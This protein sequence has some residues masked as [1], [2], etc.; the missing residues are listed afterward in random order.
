MIRPFAARRIHL[1]LLSGFLSLSMVAAASGERAATPWWQRETAMTKDGRL[2]FLDKPWW[3]QAQKLKNGERFTLDLNGDGKPD[4]VVTR[5][6][7]DIVE[8]ID[9][10]GRATNIWNKVSTTYVVSYRGTGIVDRMVSYID[11][12][13]SGV[14]SEMDIRYFRDGYLRYAWFAESFGGNAANIFAMNHWQYAGNDHGSQFRGNAQ[15]YLNKYDPIHK[16]WVPISEC[17]FS[18]WDLDNDGRADVTLRVSA[19]PRNSLHGPDTD[20]ANNYDYMW[21]KDA[22]PLSDMGALNM[23][24]SFN[25]DPHPRLDPVDKP[26]S[27]FSFT[28]VGD[29]P[30]SYAGM[31]DFNAMRR[32][33][34]TTV[35]MAWRQ[36][37]S[38][39]M[40]YPASATGFT[41]DEAR[42]NFRWEGQFWIYEREYL[43]NTGSPTE[44]WNMRREYTGKMTNRRELYFSPVDSRFHMKGAQEGWLEAGHLVSDNKDL[45]FRWWD[46]NGDGYLDTLEVFRRNATKPSRVA[47][48]DPRP[49]AAPLNPMLLSSLYNTKILPQNIA[50]DTKLITAMTV[51]TNDSTAKNYEQAAAS[52]NALERKRYCLDIAR[53]LLY[54]DIRDLVMAREKAS[55]YPAAVVDAKRFR[56]PAHGSEKT[57]YT[58]GDSLSFWSDIRML[59][60]M[61]DDY[62]EGKFSAVGLD[63]KKLN[64]DTRVG[65]NA[66]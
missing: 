24:L 46:T 22:T 53:E 39:A 28:M 8:A 26:H 18:F 12:H 27:N 23:R 29:Q 11:G 44:R 65:K 61:D 66:Q 7:G 59:H 40:N 58:L 45:E 37:W 35:H 3:P 43:S 55:V 56:D 17:P 31:Y 25:I 64:L 14:A 42:T 20:Y 54:L 13:N 57:G 62:A 10:T 5:I 6:D 52:S 2:T 50:A 19:A 47:H 63:I 9:D 4:T 1:M 33:P 30:Y 49:Q 48:F 15:I 38:A 41:W 16:A 32:P 36:R 60:Q 51:I 34:Q 21:A